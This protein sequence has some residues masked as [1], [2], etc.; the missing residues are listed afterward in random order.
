MTID[1]LNPGQKLKLNIGKSK[2]TY[3]SQI[4]DIAK[5]GTLLIDTPI[6][7]GH[8]VPVRIGSII[9]IIYFTKEGLYTF[10]AKVLNRFSG[11]LFLLQVEA[12]SQ[13]EKLQRRQYFRLER[14]IPFTF[15]IQNDPEDKIYEGV[16][17]DI[18]GGGLRSRIRNKLSIGDILNCKFKLDTEI[19][20][21]SK[22]IRFEE[23]EGKEYEIGLCYMYVDNK[24][25]EKIIS[26]IFQE[27]RKNRI[28]GIE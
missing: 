22:V 15:T 25:R 16:I 8:I 28:K 3:S 5:D 14:I 26:Y 18:S 21:L 10:Y 19:N 7:N 13:V 23:L 11:K 24:T 20:V 6:Y 17:E 2:V 4:Q 1:K 9:Q 12:I 27:Q